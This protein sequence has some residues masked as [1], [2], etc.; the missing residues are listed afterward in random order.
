MDECELLKSVFGVPETD[1][2]EALRHADGGLIVE[3]SAVSI[4]DV[5]SRSQTADFLGVKKTAIPIYS[6]FKVTLIVNTFFLY[7]SLRP[8][9]TTTCPRS[10]GGG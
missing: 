2:Q 10:T 5:C 8:T 7:F 3:V 1:V 4:N 6:S 9:T